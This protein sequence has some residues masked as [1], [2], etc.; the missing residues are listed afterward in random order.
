MG[1]KQSLFRIFAFLAIGVFCI[2]VAIICFDYYG[3]FLGDY[4]YPNYSYYGGDAYTG[5]Q[6]G[7]VDTA[8]NVRE[9]GQQISKYLRELLYGINDIAGYI[10]IITG[11]IMIVIGID[12]FIT[13]GKM[14]K[15][16]SSAE[17]PSGKNTQDISPDE[18][19]KKYRE[20]LNEGIISQEEYNE[21]RKEILGL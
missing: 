9:A 8:N 4:T 21:K 20:F 3:Y 7:T 12:G 11:L 19:L 2:V 18:K 15:K 14:A 16:Y 6:N 13:N 17:M 1:K 10:F 5:I